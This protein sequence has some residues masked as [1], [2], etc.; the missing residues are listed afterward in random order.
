MVNRI[1]QR[2]DA[3]DA[4][5]FGYLIRSGIGTYDL[6]G[7]GV[8]PV[9]RPARAW[10]TFLRTHG[11]DQDLLQTWLWMTENRLT[12][13]K[14]AVEL[15]STLWQHKSFGSA[16]EVWSTWLG[17]LSD[18]YLHPQR[19]A[20]VRFQNEPGGSVFDWTL[21]APASVEISRRDGLDVHFSGEE[22]VN[23]TGVHQFATVGPGRYRLSAEV[24]SEGITTDQGPFLHAFD[25]TDPRRLS[26]QTQPLTGNVSRSWMS[27][28][29]KVPAG[30]EA[31]QVQIERYPSLRFDNKIVGTLHVYQ[32]SLLPLP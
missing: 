15:T 21:E 22:N 18:G 8:P 25:P 31:L 10:L 1:L 11:S 19:L 32:V 17:P 24:S 12:D 28:D 30:T 16:Q 5:I 6:L 27:V 14:S 3:Y 23:F 2:T 9:A 7:T 20:N 26:V 13:Q 29:F 4:N